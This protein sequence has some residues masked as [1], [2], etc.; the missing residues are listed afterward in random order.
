MARSLNDLLARY[1]AN[2]GTEREKGTYFERLTQVWLRH[3]PTQHGLYSRVLT[4]AEWA[5]ERGEDATD[6][7]IDLV[8]QLADAPDTWCAVQCKFYKEGYRIRRE[9]IDS[10]FS[11]SGRVPFVRRIFVESYAGIWMMP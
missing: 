11:A 2:S 5:R 6:T 3:A 8:A 9:D 4:F 7:G 1:R 10:F